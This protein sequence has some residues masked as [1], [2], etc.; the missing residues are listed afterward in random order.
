LIQN[1]DK[2]FTHNL[3]LIA[4]EA[5]LES[6]EFALKNIDSDIDIFSKEGEKNNL[7]TEIDHRNQETII[8]IIRDHHSNHSIIGEE[9]KKT[10][11]PQPHEI[12]W[13][14]DPVDGT[15]NF[16]NR[17]P[18]F[19]VSIGVLYKGI[20]IAGAIWTPWLNNN[21]LILKASLGNGATIN[22]Q[23][24]I[25]TNQNSSKLSEGGI[26]TL[27]SNLESYF[28]IKNNKKKYIGEKR[29]LGSCAF[30]MMLIAKGISIY[31]ILGPAS[32]WDFAAG[33]IIIQ[34]SGGKILKI[35]Q[36]KKWETFNSFE[37]DYK[38]DVATIE[39]IRNW[40]GILVAGQESIINFTTNN[41]TPKKS[42]SD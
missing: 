24:N 21:N 34:E 19:S 40:K 2:K 9:D 10:A 23:K 25:I 1:I 14:I 35:S 11:K 22:N 20:P 41:L 42:W 12:A 33:I 27:P 32:S 30:E 36:N 4:E 5:A 15:T 39:K 8:S 3:A 37:N 26:A 38:I 17:I 13:V 28:E 7:V 31:G 18:I 6:G 29:V 16:V